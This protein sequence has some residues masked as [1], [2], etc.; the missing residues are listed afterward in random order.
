MTSHFRD[1]CGEHVLVIQ[2]WGATDVTED[3]GD[4]SSEIDDALE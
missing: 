4:T 2:L 3:A 1:C